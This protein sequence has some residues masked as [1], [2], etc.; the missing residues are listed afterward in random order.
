M[1]KRPFSQ[2]FQ[3]FP[4]FEKK[5]GHGQKSMPALHFLPLAAAVA[6]AAVAVAAAAGIPAAAEKDDDQ[7]DDPQAAPAAPAIVI[8]APHLST[9]RL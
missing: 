4:A 8:A 2:Y 3:A 7:D 9:S 5:G 6:A 1:K